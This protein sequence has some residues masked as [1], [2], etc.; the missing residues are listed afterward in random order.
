[1]VDLSNYHLV[2]GQ[3]GWQKFILEGKIATNRNIQKCTSMNQELNTMIQVLLSRKIYLQSL[4]TKWWIQLDPKIQ[5]IH[6]I[7][8]V[9]TTKMSRKERKKK[10]TTTFL[11]LL[12]AGFV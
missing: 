10:M 1:V 11:L 8:S 6:Y 12:C 3:T 2:Y 4:G 5:N 9:V 7:N